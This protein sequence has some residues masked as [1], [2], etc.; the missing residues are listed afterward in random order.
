MTRPKLF[1]CFL[2][3]FVLL[4]PKINAEEDLTNTESP[5]QPTTIVPNADEEVKNADKTD[6]TQKPTTLK[7]ESQDVKDSTE[8]T[9]DDE[10]ETTTLK[11]D[12]ENQ[13]KTTE[14]NTIEENSNEENATNAPSQNEN[15][16]ETKT[17]KVEKVRILKILQV[18][19]LHIELNYTVDGNPDD[20]CRPFK[21]KSEKSEKLNPVGDYRCDSPEILVQSAL[22]KMRE[23]EPN[24]D[25]IV[26][27]GDSSAHRP[28]SE[29]RGV[30]MSIVLENL[31]KKS[32]IFK[33][34]FPNAT[35]IPAL[36]NHDTFPSVFYPI[37]NSS[38]YEEYL[39]KAGNWS[40]LPQKDKENFVKCGFYSH[41]DEKSKTLFLVP[42]TN[43]YYYNKAVGMNT[44]D[45]CGQINWIENK[46]V[47]T[48]RNSFLKILITLFL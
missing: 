12:D 33:E 36:G 1:W 44:T 28:V 5:E 15:D 46:V 22:R 6:T 41:L 34:F 31:K 42:N 20:Y 18:S 38:F 2:L 26:W 35:L 4:A 24:P 29:N 47:K 23:F 27:T 7:P 8:N 16:E 14:S 21:N 32:A 11:N 17:E 25:F 3:I 48:R 40:D 37:D 43:L 45:P 9:D 19:D 30:K 13:E 10:S 39:E